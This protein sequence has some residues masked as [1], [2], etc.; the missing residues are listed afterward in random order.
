MYKVVKLMVNVNEICRIYTLR[1]QD[2][3]T[4]FQIPGYAH[5]TGHGWMGLYP[6]LVTVQLTVPNGN[7]CHGPWARLSHFN[8]LQGHT[9]TLQEENTVVS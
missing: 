2:N 4:P 9:R 7:N 3:L 6:Q 8:N 5:L 1:K